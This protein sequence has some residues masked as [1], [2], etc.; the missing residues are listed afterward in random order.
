MCLCDRLSVFVCV[1]LHDS[2]WSDTK[3]GCAFLSVCVCTVYLCFVIL[4]WLTLP[5][6]SVPLTVSR[7]FV[8]HGSVSGFEYLHLMLSLLHRWFPVGI[9]YYWWKT[10]FQFS[11]ECI[12]IACLNVTVPYQYFHWLVWIV[13]CVGLRCCVLMK[14]WCTRVYQS[15]NKKLQAVERSSIWEKLSFLLLLWQQDKVFFQLEKYLAT[16]L[17]TAILAFSCHLIRNPCYFYSLLSC[18]RVLG[19]HILM[20]TQQLRLHAVWGKSV[21]IWVPLCSCCSAPQTCA[22]FWEW[23]GTRFC[24]LHEKIPAVLCLWVH[25]IL[26]APFSCLCLIHID[27]H[28]YLA[29]D[30]SPNLFWEKCTLFPA[31]AWKLNS[32]LLWKEAHVKNNWL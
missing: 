15:S 5:F 25:V 11:S 9:I 2:V 6:F 19:M 12:L 32:P 3:T 29:A 7:F 8:Q 21:F 27:V 18:H 10:F 28:I 22:L 24:I 14:A 31:S 1:C 20:H 4:S 16:H 30:A 23:D 13:V 26:V 17:P